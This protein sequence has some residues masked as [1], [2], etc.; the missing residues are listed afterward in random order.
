[1]MPNMDGIEMYEKI[2]SDKDF[3]NVLIL[4]LT[5][6]EDYTHIAVLESG[7]DDFISNL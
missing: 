1:M 4:F 7:A 2:R 6:S 5:V 3:D